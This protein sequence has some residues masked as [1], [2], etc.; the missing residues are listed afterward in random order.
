MFN[1]ELASVLEKV[2]EIKNSVQLSNPKVP[3]GVF[4]ILCV[5]LVETLRR[6][7]GGGL[8]KGR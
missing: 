2:R 5:I 7:H 6:D 4:L 8:I 3:V 1:I